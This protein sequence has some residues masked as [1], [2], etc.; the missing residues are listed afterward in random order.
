MSD[1]DARAVLAPV[2]D[3][4][5]AAVQSI[6]P[7]ASIVIGGGMNTVENRAGCRGRINVFTGGLTLQ[8]DTHPALRGQ[9]LRRQAKVAVRQ[10][11]ADSGLGL[12]AVRCQS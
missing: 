3:Q 8:D 7:A 5:T 2:L 1:K 9:G 6:I 11:L 4:L 12:W 10:I